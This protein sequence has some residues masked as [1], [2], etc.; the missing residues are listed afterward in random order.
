M[1]V[2]NPDYECEYCEKCVPVFVDRNELSEVW[3]IISGLL[4]GMKISD[5][6]WK[7]ATE[8]LNNNRDHQK[9]KAQPTSLRQLA[10]DHAFPKELYWLLK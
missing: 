2:C 7:R 10:S 4:V 9:V 3:N 5:P 1:C 6:R 8:W